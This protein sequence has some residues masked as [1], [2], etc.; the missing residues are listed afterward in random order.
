[1]DWL[2]ILL[3]LLTGVL[4]WYFLP[5]GV[6]LVRTPLTADAHGDPLYDTWELKNDSPLPVSIL[7]A[8]AVSPDTWNQDRERFDE[9]D[10]PWNESPEGIRLHFNDETS[11]IRR[12][13]WQKDWTNQ[14]VLPGDTL[15]AIVPTNS[16]L[17][18]RY[19]RAGPGGLLE[20]RQLRIDGGA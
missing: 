14:E 15:T 1:M 2:A 16:T 10:L 17:I 13:D 5:R 12:E 8:R 20:R 6:V 7:S 4:L 3:S 11:E 18:V 9:A 19:R